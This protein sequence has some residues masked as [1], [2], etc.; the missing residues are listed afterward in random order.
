[1]QGLAAGMVKI[2]AKAKDG[3]GKSAVCLITVSDPIPATGV[4]VTN[5]DLIV[6]KGR[7]IQSGITNRSLPIQRI[8]SNIYQ[9]I[10]QLREL[11]TWKDLCKSRRSGYG[12]W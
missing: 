1:M 9:I 8:R 2:R 7:Q 12:L 4:D 5:N 10:R 11:T 6:A 3:S